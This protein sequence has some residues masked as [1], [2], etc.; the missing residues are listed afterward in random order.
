MQ[1][2]YSFPV[3]T[4]SYFKAMNIVEERSKFLESYDYTPKFIYSKSFNEHTLS[5]R[6][7]SMPKS[8]AEY[9][10]LECV[11]SGARLQ[12]HD[13]EL[14]RFRKINADI[15]GTP[16][17]AYAKGLMFRLLK[18]SSLSDTTRGY[19]EYIIKLLGNVELSD[20]LELP[21]EKT[22]L[23]YREYFHRYRKPDGRRN[24]DVPAVIRRELEN[25]GLAKLG[26]DVKLTDDSSSAKTYHQNKLIKV[27]KFYESRK[28]RAAERIA[29][30]EVYGHALRGPQVSLAESEG[31]ALL[32]EQ[33][34][35]REFRFRRSYRY[36]AASLGWG[37]FGSPMTFRQVYEII[38]RVMVI[39][40]NYSEKDAKDY[41]FFECYR[42]FRGGRPDIPG[43]VYLKD[44][45]YFESNMDVW[46]RLSEDEI[47]YDKFVD[48][49]EGRSTIIT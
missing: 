47:D 42:V 29:V 24:Y 15:F 48:V 30:H 17:E 37:V 14:K 7:S 8:S 46:H 33:L 41:T 38:W 5:N 3:A 31:F 35:G 25:S 20:T 2:K 13:N 45:V 34:I 49:I 1:V 12:N 40:S 28:S 6:L 16:R 18:L 39:A 10:S 36:L 27:G 23:K 19:Y 11:I 9:K 43:A 21:S 26:W 4:H 32:L 22:F 44:L